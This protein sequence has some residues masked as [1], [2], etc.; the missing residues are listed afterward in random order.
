MWRLGRCD[1]QPCIHEGE[2]AANTQT[3]LHPKLTCFPAQEALFTPDAISSCPIR[4]CLPN[5]EYESRHTTRS[6]TAPTSL[7]TISTAT[8]L[9]PLPTR[10]LRHT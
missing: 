2:I 8:V 5:T 3:V 4:P 1:G 10:T 6:P 9:E 7:L